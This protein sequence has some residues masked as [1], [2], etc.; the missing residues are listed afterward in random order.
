[1]ECSSVG[2]ISLGRPGNAGLCIKFALRC[3]IPLLF[4]RVCSSAGPINRQ[5]MALITDASC[6][7]RDVSGRGLNDMGASNRCMTRA[8]EETE[9]RKKL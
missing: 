5:T 1:M 2:T 9:E 7:L 8:R 4:D 3:S 6:T